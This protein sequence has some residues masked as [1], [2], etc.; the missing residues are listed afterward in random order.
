[1]KLFDGQVHVLEIAGLI[2][3]SVF[4]HAIGYSLPILAAILLILWPLLLLQMLAEGLLI[5]V[6]GGIERL[7]RKA[8][9]PKPKPVAPP[10]ASV[11]PR[12]GIARYLWYVPLLTMTAG[13]ARY[14]YETGRWFL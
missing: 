6:F 10:K 3:A 5:A 4:A 2:V 11:V 7:Y 8:R 9:P 12:T 14:V 1:M 13:Y